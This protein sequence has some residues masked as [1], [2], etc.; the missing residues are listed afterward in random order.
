MAAHFT[1]DGGKQVG[2][3]TVSD[4]LRDKEKWTST[5]KDG[6]SSLRQRMGRHDTLEQALLLWFNDVRA[7]N[8]IINDDM[9][10]EKAKT[11]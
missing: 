3:S 8:S 10:T 11:Y 4:I 6:D 1:R 2:R 9:L 5:P 7:K